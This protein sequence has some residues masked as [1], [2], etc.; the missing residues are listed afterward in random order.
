[1]ARLHF[2]TVPTTK[3]IETKILKPVVALLFANYD[4]NSTFQIFTNP[5]EMIQYFESRIDN[6]MKNMMQIRL[7]DD[8]AFIRIFNDQSLPDMLTPSNRRE[9]SLRDQF[10]KPNC[11]SSSNNEQSDMTTDTHLD[12]KINVNDV[13][14][15]WKNFND[16][17]DKQSIQ[18]NN[19]SNGSDSFELHVNAPFP[20][21]TIKPNIIMRRISTIT[22]SAGNS[23]TIIKYQYDDKIHEIVTKRN[24][25]NVETKVE[26]FANVNEGDTWLG[27][28]FGETLLGDSLWDRFSNPP[29]K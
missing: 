2:R 20:H 10:L 7:D 27:L 3:R 22:D 11:T 19:D 14:L 28:K 16:V 26:H 15:A 12:G 24:K 8:A 17:D 21:M 5:F 13:L 4:R 6:M 18:S 9:Y 1:M 23:K 29:Q 25:D